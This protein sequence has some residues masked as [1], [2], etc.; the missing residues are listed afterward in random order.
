M[1]R[2]HR[3]SVPVRMT[4]ATRA[5]RAEMGALLAAIE[6]HA[7]QESVLKALE[8]QD[9]QSMAELAT[10]LQVQP[11]T[12][13]KMV[14]RLAS[15]GHVQKRGSDQ[16]GRRMHVFLTESGV[17]ALGEIDRMLKKIDGKAFKGIGAKDQKK[18]GR[19]LRRV[20][21]NLGADKPSN[22]T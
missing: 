15:R 22:S 7:G 11:P 4:T 10:A 6:L 2:A 13:T 17:T 1:A 3:K 5:Y 21:R 16:D 12:V 19:M 20:A 8:E 9:G 18:L 14:G